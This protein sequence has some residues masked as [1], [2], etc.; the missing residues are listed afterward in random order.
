VSLLLFVG[1]SLLAAL[2]LVGTWYSEGPPKRRVV[3]WQ[4]MI[5]S[6]ILAG[7]YNVI[8]GQWGFV[9]STVVLCW[10]RRRNLRLARADVR[11]A[12]SCRCEVTFGES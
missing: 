4:I 2:L 5:V 9:I 1:S 6:A 8:T 12:G 11:R 7:V 10:V 3:G